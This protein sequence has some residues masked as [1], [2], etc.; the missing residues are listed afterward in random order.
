MRRRRVDY[1]LLKCS[2][3]GLRQPRSGMS[4]LHWIE[5][6]VAGRIAI[7][8]RPRA[9]AWLE[10]EI[11]EWKNAGVDVAVSLLENEE[12]SDLGLQREAELCRSRGIGFISF[13][14]PDRGLPE[15]R[16]EAS[17]IAHSLAAGLR[18]GRSI[19]IHCRAGIGRSSEIATC[20]LIC[21]GIEAEEALAQIRASRGLIVPDTDAQ[22]EWVVAFGHMQRDEVPPGGR[23][24]R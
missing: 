3:R 1:V 11:N 2:G 9:D 4:R 15:S 23:S 12:V 16:R 10:A 19:A 8:A 17:Q 7:M 20:A 13:P 6:R 5:T 18:D 14:I 22:R 24:G 21:C